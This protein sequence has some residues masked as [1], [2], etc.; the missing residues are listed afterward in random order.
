MM[1]HLDS[2]SFPTVNV[3]AT[4]PLFSKDRL[5]FDTETYTSPSWVIVEKGNLSKA[6]VLV[7]TMILR[8]RLFNEWFPS[9]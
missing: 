9:R 7:F 1:L 8:L 3:T 5:R 6:F 2:P 4:I